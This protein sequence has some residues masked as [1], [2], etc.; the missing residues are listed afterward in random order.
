MKHVLL[1]SCHYTYE[2]VTHGPLKFKMFVAPLASFAKVNPHLFFFLCQTWLIDVNT[3]GPL[4][5]INVQFVYKA[6]K[7]FTRKN[8]FVGMSDSHLKK[9]KNLY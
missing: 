3:D 9:K 7:H 8:R 4:T 5:E 2:H 1:I 6:I